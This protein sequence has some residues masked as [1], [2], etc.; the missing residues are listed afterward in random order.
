MSHFKDKNIL[1]P[2][3]IYSFISNNFNVYN[4]DSIYK[5]YYDLFNSNI[6]LFTHLKDYW[7]VQL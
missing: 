5:L 2:K 4:I 6:V 3:D 7:I 1:F